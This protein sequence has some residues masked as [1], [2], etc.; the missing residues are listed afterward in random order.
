MDKITAII[1]ATAGP[2]LFFVVVASGTESIYR[3]SSPPMR[4]AAAP[5][6]EVE[7]A[8]V[9]DTAEVEVEATETVEAVIEEETTE[10]AEATPEA[11]AEAS[12]AV[13]ATPETAAE[14]VAEEDATELAEAAPETDAAEAPAAEAV[15]AEEA[16]PEAD[17]VEAP[18]AEAVVAEEAAPETDAVEETAAAAAATED[19]AETTEPE[20]AAVVIA[21][22]PA[23]GAKVWRQCATCHLA[24]KE[25]NR[26]GP[27]LVNVLGRDIASIEGF[28][29]SG[30]LKDIEGV[31]TVERMSAWL[32]NPKAFARGT[33][34]AFRGL[35]DATDREN[36]IAYL[37]SL[38]SQ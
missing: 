13:E 16:A 15:V 31:W 28:R 25:Q 24:D 20:V 18:A 6:A 9:Q 10:I 3:V 38:S 33:K 1:L 37:D 27:H 21:G 34:M 7:E 19:A 35:R 11:A 17:A 36:L 30:D 29:Y 22:D 32:E 2:A 26:M 5:V 4:S 12:T 23:E 8:E 14:A